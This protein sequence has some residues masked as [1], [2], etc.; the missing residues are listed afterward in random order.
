M[1]AWKYVGKKLIASR[2]PKETEKPVTL[3]RAPALKSLRRDANQGQVVS[4]GTTFSNAAA[5]ST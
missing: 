5:A 1:Q 4:A 2:A 3:A